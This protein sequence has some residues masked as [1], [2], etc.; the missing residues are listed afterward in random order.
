MGT[1]LGDGRRD[2]GE[3]SL[4]ARQPFDHRD[5]PTGFVQGERRR[6]LGGLARALPA[7]A[8]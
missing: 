2:L 6:L 3:R 1:G 8:G 7:R 4:A 5:H